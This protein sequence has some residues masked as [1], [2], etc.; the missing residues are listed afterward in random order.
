MRGTSDQ[1]IESL[2]ALTP[3]IGP[4]EHPIRRIKPLADRM[5][6]EL[7]PTLASCTPRAQRHSALDRLTRCHSECAASQRVRKRVEEMFGWLKTIGD[8]RKIRY[9]GVGR[10]G[11]RAEMA[12]PAYSLVRKATLMPPAVISGAGPCL[13]RCNAPT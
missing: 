4:K 11:L 7:S 13:L 8:E 10:N 9:C 2:V 5:P 1:Q 6:Q 3:R 12:L